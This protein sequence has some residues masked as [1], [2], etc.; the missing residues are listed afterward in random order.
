M[1]GKKKSIFVADVGD[2]NKYKNSMNSFKS[3]WILSLFQSKYIL[4]PIFTNDFLNC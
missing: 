4:I 3:Y 1:N 2:V